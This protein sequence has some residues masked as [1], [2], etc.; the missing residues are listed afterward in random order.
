MKLYLIKR[1]NSDGKISYRSAGVY[2]NWTSCGK[3]WTNGSFKS[4][5]NYDKSTS[6]VIL[7]DSETCDIKVITVDLKDNTVVETPFQVWYYENMKRSI[8]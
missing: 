1:I 6:N 4:F 2:P 3:C 5:L 8:Q 7:K